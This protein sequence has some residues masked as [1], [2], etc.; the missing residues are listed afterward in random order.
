[1]YVDSRTGAA[2]EHL[3]LS[4][5]PSDFSLGRRRG[6]PGGAYDVQ[7]P[8]GVHQV[9]TAGGASSSNTM[10]MEFVRSFVLFVWFLTSDSL[11]GLVVPMFRSVTK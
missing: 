9:H 1:M 2:T 5:D 3:P 8:G 6:E 10:A 7:L 11:V 4:W